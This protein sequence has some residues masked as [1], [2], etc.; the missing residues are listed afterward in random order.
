MSRK[1]LFAVLLALALPLTCYFLLKHFAAGAVVMPKR[2]FYDTVVTRD[3]YGKTVQDTI[4]HRVRNFT[5]TNQLDKQVSL[6]DLKDKIIVADFFFTSCPTICPALTRNMKRLQDAF[7]KTDTVVRF[8]SFTVDPKRDSV[9]RL[10]KYS[11]KFGINPDTWWLLTGSKEEIYDIAKN[12]FK[13]N[14]ADTN[15]DTNFIHTEYFFMLDKD[16]V[17]RG[18][19][20]GLDSLHLNKLADDIVLLMLE[21][22][23]K[24]RGI[25][26][27]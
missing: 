20:N 27:E 1:S 25:R 7:N 3:D 2:Y 10:K 14:I 12:E 13:A 16:R 9:E 4:W 17:V 5:L 26:Q 24:K 21:K 8:L 6:S 22:D 19:Y 23:R 18:W 11:D 15:I